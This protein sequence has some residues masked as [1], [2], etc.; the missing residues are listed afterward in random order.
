M[1]VARPAVAVQRYQS[2][3]V[4]GARITLLGGLAEPFRCS[5]GVAIDPLAGKVHQPERHLRRRNALYG[6]SLIPAGG[7]RKILLHPVTIGVEDAEAKLGSGAALSGGERVPVP[8][9]PIIGLATDP[10][11]VN[12]P[13]IGLRVGDPLLGGR[14]APM[15]RPGW[16]LRDVEPV[17]K[18][19]R[20]IVVG[21]LGVALGGGTIPTR[22]AR[23]LRAITF[24][25]Q[26]AELMLCHSVTQLR[27]PPVPAGGIGE[28]GDNP[29]AAGVEQSQAIEGFWISGDCRR[30]PFLE[31]CRVIATFIRVMAAIHHRHGMG[32]LE[33]S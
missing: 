21:G 1:L 29:V 8:S 22:K 17:W 24:E 27:R 23:R 26:Q 19:Q 12:Q 4:L 2:Q 5:V 25:V 32:T 15:Q 10:P 6:C 18:E 30:R 9:F 7:G 31:R 33:K 11:C 13:G 16:V 14:L 20:S 28:I 3:I